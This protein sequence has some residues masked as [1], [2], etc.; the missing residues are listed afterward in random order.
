[1]ARLPKPIYFPMDCPWPSDE[2]KVIDAQAR[3]RFN[4]LVAKK[5]YSDL[6]LIYSMHWASQGIWIEFK[7]VKLSPLDT[8]IVHKHNA[9]PKP[10]VPSA[11]V[12]SGDEEGE[13]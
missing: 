8:L 11:T 3:K 2:S 10:W 4:Q 12:E 5:C 6:Y 7:E 1:M 9:N 13:E